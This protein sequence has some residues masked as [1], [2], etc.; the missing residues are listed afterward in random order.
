VL[1]AKLAT[2][3]ALGAVVGTVLLGVAIAIEKPVLGTEDLTLG[4]GDGEIQRPDRM[5]PARPLVTTQS[6]NAAAAGE[7]VPL[8]G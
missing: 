1:I 3:A 8:V 2:Y 6:Q 5:P 7:K 4:L